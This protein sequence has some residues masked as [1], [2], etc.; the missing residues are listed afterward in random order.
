MHLTLSPSLKGQEAQL[1]CKNLY[2]EGID[3]LAKSDFYSVSVR[4][5]AF[6]TAAPAVSQHKIYRD[7][8]RDH[9]H[10]I[11]LQHWDEAMRTAGAGALRDLLLLSSESD[12][13]E[14]VARE[15]SFRSW[16]VWIKRAEC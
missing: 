10:S 14:S 5:I 4:R 15:V 12:L 2:P 6:G 7:E 11:T 16:L 8:L 1:T 9:L 13:T 3:V